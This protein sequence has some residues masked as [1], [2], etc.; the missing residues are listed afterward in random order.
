MLNNNQIKLVQTAVRAAGLRSPKFDGRYRLLLAQYKRS[1][2]AMV[3]SC[4]QLTNSQLEDLLAICESHGW[5]CP[6]K[7][8]DFFRSK[9]AKNAPSRFASQSEAEGGDSAS[10]AQQEAIKNLAGDL[11]WNDNNLTGMIKRIT[12]QRCSN[13]AELTSKEAFGLIEALKA[14]LCRSVGKNYH[15]LSEIKDDFAKE[16]KDGC[17][18]T[19]QV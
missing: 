18:Q 15:N 6:G 19:A 2:G 17:K 1:N 13:I 10:F 16:V 4:K 7:A 5:R 9:V 3:A 11:G 8:E 14:I 12:R